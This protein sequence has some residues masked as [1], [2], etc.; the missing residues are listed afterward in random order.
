[1]PYIV[2]SF[3]TCKSGL[4]VAPATRAKQRT[5]TTTL[6]FTVDSMLLRELGERLVGRSH[7]ALAELIKNSYDADA[8]M[9]DVVFAGDSIVVRD[10]GHGMTYDEFRDYWMRIGSPHKERQIVSRTLKRPLTGSKGVGRLAAQ[11]LA[12]RVEVRS[13]SAHSSDEELVATVNWDD[14]V[15]AGS[16]TQATALVR[17]E[18]PSTKLPLGSEHG[19]WIRMDGLKNEWNEPSFVELARELWPLQ[20][21]FARSA[22][23]TTEDVGTDARPATEATTPEAVLTSLDAERPRRRRRRPAGSFEI[24]L[25]AGRDD[26]AARFAEEMRRVLDLWSA[27]IT[28]RLDVTE[29]SGRATGKLTVNVEFASGDRQRLEMDYKRQPL[30]DLRFDVRVYSLH[31]RQRYGIAVDTA[32]DYLKRNGGVHVYDAGFHLP[33]YGVNTDWLGLEQAHANRLSKSELLPKDLNVNRGLNALPTNRRVYG[34]AEV[35]TSRERRMTAP[36]RQASDALTIQVTRDRLVENNALRYLTDYV[37]VALDFYAVEETRRGKRE[38]PSEPAEPAPA[39]ARRVREVLS[40]HRGDITPAAYSSLANELDAVI[41]AVNTEAEVQAAQASL[42]GVL[43]TAGITAIAF[44]H[45]F[46]R[47]LTTLEALARRLRTAGSLKDARDVATSIQRTVADARANRR[48]FDHAVNEADR[49]ERRA[50]RLRPILDGTASQLEPFLR[51]IAVDNSAVPPEFRLPPGT[52]AEWG[53]LF[54]NVYVNAVNALVDCDRRE[55]V[56]RTTRGGRTTRVLIEDSGRGIDLRDAESLFEPFHRVQ[57]ISEERRGLGLG[58]SGLGLTIVRMI[59]TRLGCT[60]RFVAP[61]D[62]FSTAL[63]LAWDRK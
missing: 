48:L 47:Q 29:R 27:R 8:S 59:A 5:T 24:R 51:G 39:K 52:R 12:H 19:T 41:D 40:Q 42:L 54:Q 38:L 32:R 44:E 53:S 34:V 28:G 20:P 4:Q 36:N 33:H 62:G 3:P 35:N 21:P 6:P 14:A 2:S 10:D 30:H 45:E 23:T 50:Y 58:G 37:R 22:A 15:R 55:V 60:V 9:V 61:A 46:N 49:S 57:A 26:Y 63:E 43:A 11:F 17:V 25:R 31:H 56:A 13:R 18:K 1:M 7:I 16:L